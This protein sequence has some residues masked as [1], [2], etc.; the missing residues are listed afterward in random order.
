MQKILAVFE[1]T[2]KKVKEPAFSLLFV[3]AAVVGSCVSDMESLSFSSQEN[4]LLFGLVSLEQ[5]P[6]LLAGFVIILFMSLIV[7]IFAGATDI[8]KDI[9]SRMIVMVLGKPVSRME[10]LIG[11]YLGIVSICLVFFIIAAMSAGVAHYVKTQEFFPLSVFARQFFLLLAVF[12]VA[13]VATMISTFFGDISAMIVTASYLFISLIVTAVAVFVDMLPRSLGLGSPV[14]IIAY[15]FPNFFF[16]F[17]SFKFPGIVLGALIVYSLALTVIFL[18]IAA[19]RMQHR[20]M[21]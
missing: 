15:F 13:A 14:N 21:I 20:D 5:G 17:N 6:P 1:M 12:P 16:F 4:S 18:I 8:P 10:Y 19:I 7:A 9:Q 3:I 2:V 11:K